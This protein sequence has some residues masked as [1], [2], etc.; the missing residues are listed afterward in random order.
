M[1]FDTH[2][3]YD[4]YDKCIEKGTIVA[5]TTNDTVRIGQVTGFEASEESKWGGQNSTIWA[6]IR[7]FNTG[8]IFRIKTSK[9][10]N[11]ENH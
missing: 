4:V 1:K 8:T 3:F 2:F 11:I 7:E 5:F 10:V 9:L 6:T